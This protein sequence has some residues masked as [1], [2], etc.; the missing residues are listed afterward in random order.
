MT[1]AAK[2]LEAIDNDPRLGT[3]EYAAAL[4]HAA[5]TTTDLD[6]RADAHAHLMLIVAGY[7]RPIAIEGS[8]WWY[9]ATMPTE[10][11]VAA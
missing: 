5:G 2:W 10:Y 11:P 4:A 9:D 7:L 3:N 6:N 1:N 8:E